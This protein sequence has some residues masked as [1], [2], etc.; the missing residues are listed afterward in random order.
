ML[1]RIL[2]IGIGLLCYTNIIKAQSLRCN[3]KYA[4]KRT[5]TIRTKG[6]R[7]TDLIA[8]SLLITSGALMQ[9]NAKLK[10]FNVDLRDAIQAN[11]HPKLRFDDYI[12]YAP[13]ASVYLMKVCGV[14]NKH[15][16]RDLLTLTA[17]SY[18]LGGLTVVATKNICH[19]QRPDNTSFNSFPSGH[20]FTAFFGAE[21]IRREF[22]E[23]Y[24]AIAVAG[25]TVAATTGFMRIY[26]NRHW[27][28]DVLAGAGIGILSVSAAY[29]MYPWLCRV[30]WKDEPSNNLRANRKT[31]AELTLT[32]GGVA[33]TF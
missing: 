27:L 23:E 16:Y 21:L 17:T 22:G 5:D 28:A 8:P 24:P 32:P 26:N 18:I 12:Q 20:T 6:F 10:S 11:G 4:I 2:L 3:I 14:N 30:L 19:I 31:T 9:G 29:W 25:Y 33:L 13:L 15:N 1:L 7:A